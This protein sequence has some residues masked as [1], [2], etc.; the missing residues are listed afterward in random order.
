MKYG[1]IVDQLK[2]LKPGIYN[3]CKCLLV[4]VMKNTCRCCLERRNQG[5]SRLLDQTDRPGGD[6]APDLEF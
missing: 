2:H 6:L 5:R 3:V 4:N 1:T